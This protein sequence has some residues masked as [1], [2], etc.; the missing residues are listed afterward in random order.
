MFI[1]NHAPTQE[2][3]AIVNAARQGS[4]I[5]IRA[6]AGSG[7]TSTCML[8]ANAVVRPSLYIAFNKAIADEA[9]KE[10]P[11]WVEC[12][13]VHSMAYRAIVDAKMRAKLQG[14]FAFSDIIPDSMLD[15]MDSISK[16][17]IIK[18]R[19]SVTDIIK[20]YCQSDMVSLEDFVQE[21]FPLWADMDILNSYWSKLVDKNSTTKITHDVYLK[22]YQ[23]SNPV[24]KYQTI[25][26]DEAQD[27]SPVVLSIVLSQKCQVIMVGDQYQSIYEW[28]GA[29]NALS[30]LPPD[31][32]NLYLTESFRFT[33]AIADQATNL[34]NI[35]GND[36][37]IIG[38][39]NID[40][41]NPTTATKCTIVRTNATI[42]Q[43]LLRAS[44]QGKLVY[45][46]AD[47]KDLWCKMYHINA[48]QFKERPKFP[49]K[50]LSQYKTYE[51]LQ[52][53]GKDLPELARLVRLT[54]SLTS[55]GLQSNINCIKKVIV[56]RE[57]DADFTL[58]TGHKSKGLK[59]DEVT[60]TDDVLIVREGSDLAETLS[61]GQ[62]IELL[63][64][65]V[66]RAKYILNLPTEVSY[67]INNW[68]VVKEELDNFNN[69]YG[70]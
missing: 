6:F 36:K 49:D 58:T 28:R 40:A 59:W 33:Q 41:Y 2:Q 68:R 19:V 35:L 57:E 63:Y 5:A 39:A 24:L 32:I 16:S 45:V 54:Q 48:L 1:M 7:K 23:L 25:Y 67:V 12:R 10:F 34:I 69:N 50:E 42:L 53:A 21:V 18:F 38:R 55:G 62:T 47:L 26:L 37:Q 29:I 66:T 20:Q 22:M 65:M 27:S 52:E 8:V 15:S 56:E 64:V 4:N 11:H 31:Y 70:R 46:L 17:T 30:N 13:T 60:L 3:V 44:E 9:S 14:F 51:E 61:S 43:E